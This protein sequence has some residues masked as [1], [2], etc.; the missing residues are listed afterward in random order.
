MKL[1][2]IIISRKIIILA[3]IFMA[4]IGFYRMS[5]THAEKR[6]KEE[7]FLPGLEGKTVMIDP[8]HGGADP[9]A[10]KDGY[11]EAKLNMDLALALKK[12]LEKN[13]VR[14]KM[15]RNGDEGLVPDKKMSYSEQWLL[16]H[17]RKI[18]AET[19]KAH[20]LVSI[21]TNSHKDSSVS[22]SIV[23]YT[24]EISKSLAESV[25]SRLNSL[26]MRDRAAEQ[27]N[28]AVIKGNVMP[29]VLIE[30]G[31]ITS[32]HDRDILTS[33]SEAVARLI[34]E[35]LHIFAENLTPPQ[36]VE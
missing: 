12:E 26:D 10:V 25:Q 29:S 11:T 6:W 24:D 2:V 36:K 31:F 27:R 28:F 5:S 34:Y 8:G 30:A 4:L 7:I 14:V 33:N 18:F 15:T 17:K 23:F 20:I 16:L 22:G 21:H 32:K 13:G 9:G 3:L 1:K 35:G 19:E